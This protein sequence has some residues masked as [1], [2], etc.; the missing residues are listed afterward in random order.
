MLRRLGGLHG[1][2]GT[3]RARAIAVRRQQRSLLDDLG[4]GLNTCSRT[5]RRSSRCWP[6]TSRPPSDGL[7]RGLRRRYEAMGE[8]AL[9]S[10]TAALLARAILG[11]GTTRRSRRFSKLERGTRRAGRPPDPDP[12]ARRA[13]QAS[14]GARPFRRRRAARTR[15]RRRWRNKRTSS[16]IHADALVDLAAVLESGGRTAEASA[17]DRGCNPPLR[18][19]RATR[20]PQT[21]HEPT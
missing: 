14:R 12:L 16:T 7:R 11:A 4:R 1:L 18:A 15:G 9:R 3:V 5:P 13:G 20:S 2:A 6:A 10:T 8:N 21:Q 17:I 19:R